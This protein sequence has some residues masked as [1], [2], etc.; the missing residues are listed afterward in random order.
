[1]QKRA[2]S[3]SQIGVMGVFALSCFGILLYIWISFGGAIPLAAKGYRVKASFAEA[4]QLSDTA[5][6]RISGVT[7]GR[8]VGTG[9]VHGRTQATM[10]IDRRYVPIPR[11]TRAIL[12]QKTLL[13]ETYIELTPGD[14]RTGGL[15]DGGTL[16]NAQVA[17]TT[18][19]DE[20]TRAFDARTRTDLQRMF[21]GLAVGLAARGAAASDIRRPR[22]RGHRLA[23]RRAGSHARRELLQAAD[24]D[25]GARAARGPAG[26]G[27]PEP[28]QGGARLA[29]LRARRRHAG[30][31]EQGR[32][33]PA[34]ALR[35]CGRAVHL[36]GSRD[37][38]SAAW[39]EPP[40][41][42]LPTARAQ[43]AQAGA[44]VVR[45]P[46]R[47]QPRVRPGAA[48]PR[49]AAPAVPRAGDRLPAHPQG[50]LRLGRYTVTRRSAVVTRS[51][52]S[53]A[54]IV[55]RH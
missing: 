20:V 35:P 12:R 22:P 3:I 55:S 11:D 2:P 34:A 52:P 54:L 46:E 25:P 43:P 24:R 47:G 32:E 40:Q 30:V 17:P 1:M 5:D 42:V 50:P 8:V 10:Q 7:V 51:S 4:T 39:F 53:G 44:P 14:R 15:P 21:H 37:P 9:Q 16:P 18:E 41:P 36:G 49:A 31:G 19:L 45:L 38:G 28:V 6:V 13:G 33:R 23:R 29:D 26:R 48:V 27:L